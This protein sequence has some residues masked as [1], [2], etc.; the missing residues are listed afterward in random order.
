[1]IGKNTEQ[2]K[3]PKTILLIRAW[4]WVSLWHVFIVYFRTGYIS[5]M[6]CV[7]VRACMQSCGCMCVCELKCMCL[8]VYQKD[9]FETNWAC[10]KACILPRTLFPWHTSDDVPWCF[11]VVAMF[12]YSR[13]ILILKC[14]SRT[15]N[16]TTL[17]KWSLMTGAL[18]G[19][20]MWHV[21]LYT[22]RLGM[23]WSFVNNMHGTCVFMA[24]WG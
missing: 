5:W 1:M 7:W 12:R 22:E 19:P 9:W 21:Q 20:C 3:S 14:K 23:Q 4:K 16:S 6:D 15:Q 2:T 18:L 10:I 17:V 13:T 11:M 8:V 24:V